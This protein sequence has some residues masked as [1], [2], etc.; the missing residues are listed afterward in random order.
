MLA[1]FLDMCSNKEKKSKV[2]PFLYFLTCALKINVSQI[3]CKNNIAN[4]IMLDDILPCT[5]FFF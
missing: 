1:G 3:F 2:I 4:N 5:Q